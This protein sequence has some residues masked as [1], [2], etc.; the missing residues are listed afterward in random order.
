[1]TAG[2]KRL[3][4]RTHS[5]PKQQRQRPRRGR[6]AEAV[7]LGIACGKVAVTYLSKHG[8]LWSSGDG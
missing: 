6:C 4:A 1:M 2:S 3:A 7:S 8:W 5:G